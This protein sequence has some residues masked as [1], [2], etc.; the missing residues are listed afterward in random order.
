MRGLHVRDAMTT[1]PMFN[2]EDDLFDLLDQLKLTNAVLIIN[3]TQQLEGI[4]TSYDATEYFRRRTENIMRVEDIET[5]LKEIII[6]AYTKSTGELDEL[7]LN[8]AISRISSRGDQDH[9]PS[10]GFDRL[11][12]GDYVHLLT[13]QDTWK[14]VDPIFCIEKS[15]L[16]QLLEEIRKTRNDLAHFRK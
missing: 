5:M 2:M 4:V 12:F 16:R 1:A 14:V 7:S 6:Q 8:N 15:Y 3:P 10:I 9:Q 11:S 13:Y